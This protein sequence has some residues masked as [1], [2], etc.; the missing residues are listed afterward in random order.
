MFR[1]LSTIPIKDSET[2]SSMKEKDINKN[3]FQTKF[4]QEVP[5]FF[6]TLLLVSRLLILTNS[7]SQKWKSP[8]SKVICELSRL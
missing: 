5:Y 1:E 8:Q 2:G 4:V 3:I 7:I 6:S